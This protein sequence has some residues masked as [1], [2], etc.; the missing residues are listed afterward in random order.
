MPGKLLGIGYR[1]PDLQV[2]KTT[3]FISESP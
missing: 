1:E 3:Y 2:P